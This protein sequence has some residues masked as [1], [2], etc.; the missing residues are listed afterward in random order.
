MTDQHHKSSQRPYKKE[1][2]CY[3]PIKH[4]QQTLVGP[5]W[6]PDHSWPTLDLVSEY[7]KKQREQGRSRS[8][9]IIKSPL[10]L[11]QNPTA[12]HAM[13]LLMDHYP[14]MRGGGMSKCHNS[15]LANE[16]HVE[17]YFLIFRRSVALGT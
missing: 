8:Q 9:R 5:I 12:Y 3:V 10:K 16:A 17:N 13:L 7:C 4:F 1:W 14:G 2:V 6:H 11:S 15:F